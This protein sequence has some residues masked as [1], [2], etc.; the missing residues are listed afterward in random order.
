M[1]PSFLLVEFKLNSSYALRRAVP[2]SFPL[3]THSQAIYKV[4]YILPSS[5][6]SKPRVF[7]LFQ[8]L[9]G[10]G[11]IIPKLERRSF[12]YSDLQE[13][14]NALAANASNTPPR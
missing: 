9:P 2:Y 7:T 5:V 3:P 12:G 14:P 1:H 10:W 4:P 6:C 13:Y 11:G 8:K